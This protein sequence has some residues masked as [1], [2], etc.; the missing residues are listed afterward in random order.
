MSD[1]AQS[2]NPR[3]AMSLS[4]TPG[5]QDAVSSRLRN[6]GACRYFSTPGGGAVGRGEYAFQATELWQ[7]V[8]W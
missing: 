3:F 7:A 2:Y 4:K 5:Q 6:P 1:E 8:Y